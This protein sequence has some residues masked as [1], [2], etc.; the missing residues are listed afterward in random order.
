MEVVVEEE[1]RSRA[2]DGLWLVTSVVM[3]TEPEFSCSEKPDDIMV[4]LF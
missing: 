4:R 3:A 1:V 2:C